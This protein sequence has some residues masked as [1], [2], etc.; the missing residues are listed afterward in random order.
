M[1]KNERFENMQRLMLSPAVDKLPFLERLQEVAGD[2]AAE[3]IYWRIMNPR[4]S[5]TPQ[6]ADIMSILQTADFRQPHQTYKLSR[7]CARRDIEIPLAKHDS[8]EYIIRTGDEGLELQESLQPGT[9]IYN[10]HV[11]VREF[12]ASL[13]P[14]AADPEPEPP[15]PK[16]VIELGHLC[17]KDLAGE[18]PEYLQRTSFVAMI[19]A[20]TPR[21]SLWL[22][23]DY[24]PSTDLGDRVD[25]SSGYDRWNVF[26]DVGLEFDAAQLVPDVHDWNDGL[27]MKA[28]EDCVQKTCRVVEPAVRVARTLDVD[29]ALAERWGPR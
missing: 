29:K 3:F 24:Q 12:E 19:D 11:A 4:R 25:M 8:F 7:A 22:F 14:S 16:F 27:M 1:A 9:N 10:S 13:P 17:F 26:P 15:L 6:P 20:T 28:L 23:H 2:E 18:M 21:K 5:A